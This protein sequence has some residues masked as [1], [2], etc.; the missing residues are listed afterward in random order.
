MVSLVVYITSGQRNQRI[1]SEAIVLADTRVAWIFEPVAPQPDPE[2]SFELSSESI[3]L[4]SASSPKAAQE[5]PLFGYPSLVEIELIENWPRDEAFA[6]LKDMMLDFDPVVRLAALDS[7]AT[8]NHPGIVS[9]LVTALGDPEPQLRIAALDAVALQDDTTLIPNIEALLYDADAEVRIAAIDT[10]S[11]LENRQAVPMLAGLLYDQDV[12]IRR[13]NVN[14]L[15]EIGGEDAV[16]YLL[17][18]RN[19]PD[20]VVRENAASI[21][22]ELVGNLD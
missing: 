22:T 21:L 19:D 9:I 15:G 10:L 2:P 3:E 17:Q 18:A 13:H 14:A 11:D 7:L 20:R 1:E 8:M 16:L 5:L 4:P 6:A 12:E